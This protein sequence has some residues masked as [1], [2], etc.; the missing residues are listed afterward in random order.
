[1]THRYGQHRKR[2]RAAAEPDATVGVDGGA[3]EQQEQQSDPRKE[4]QQQPENTAPWE[5]LDITG[6]TSELPSVAQRSSPR[7][8]E[9][10]D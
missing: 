6:E 9:S 2:K 5:D 8:N 10:T 4:Q 7:P 1:M 3:A